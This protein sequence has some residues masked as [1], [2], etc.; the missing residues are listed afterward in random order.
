MFKVKNSNIIPI[1]VTDTNKAFFYI[2][3]HKQPIY[4]ARVDNIKLF[5][6]YFDNVI[7]N[8]FVYVQ[9]IQQ[10]AIREGDTVHLFK[11]RIMKT[12]IE[13]IDKPD[14]NNNSSIFDHIVKKMEQFEK[15]CKESKYV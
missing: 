5:E 2:D 6:V 13:N 8:Q 7:E 14:K 10:L 9:D 1:Y 3:R 15:W 12:I 11:T 4:F